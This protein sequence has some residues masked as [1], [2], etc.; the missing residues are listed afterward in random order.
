M[1]VAGGLIGYALSA[2]TGWYG[3]GI[4]AVIGILV[5]ALIYAQLRDRQK[6]AK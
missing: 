4:G 5:G 6:H 3:T 1:A 2:A